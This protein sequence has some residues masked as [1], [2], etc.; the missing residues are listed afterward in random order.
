M[1]D[2]ELRR[3]LD[4]FAAAAPR[5][6]PRPGFAARLRR[7]RRA[8]VA[9]VAVAAC[10]A[11]AGSAVVVSGGEPA[12]RVVAASESPTAAPAPSAVTSSPPPT[13]SVTAHPT[14]SPYHGTPP[15]FP[16]PTATTAEPSTPPAEPVT[17]S[18]R[19]GHGLTLTATYDPGDLP[20]A[21]LGTLVVEASDDDG[22]IYPGGITWGDG[23]S[24]PAMMVAA[25]CV[26]DPM[27]TPL[28]S[29]EPH[30]AHWRQELPHA[31]RHA[32]DYALRVVVH[33]YLVCHGE[34]PREE[35]EVTLHVRARPG[36][37]A[38]NGP[39]KPVYRHDQPTVQDRTVNLSGQLDDDDGWLRG[40][41]IGWG[42]GTSSV[43]RNDRA[44]DDGAGRHYPFEGGLWPSEDHTYAEPGTY[45][46]TLRYTSTGCGGAD[47]Q[48]GDATVT[49][50]VR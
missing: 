49:V 1:N 25:S 12:R 29:R 4:A 3:A 47:V 37:E 41:T 2:D 32:G 14:I 44:C 21:T 20:T 17:A 5:T 16:S 19:G 9:A 31:W 38:S 7:R 48:G 45:T 42:D 11:V 18:A 36:R 23:T 43:V 8:Q 6:D 10:L 33:S 50:T 13:H 46:I 40:V 27:P 28:R 22:E 39:A 26:Q 15:S 34:V 35:A 24:E 30:P